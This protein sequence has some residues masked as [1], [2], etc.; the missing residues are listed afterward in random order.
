MVTVGWAMTM[1]GKYNFIQSVGRAFAILEQFSHDQRSLGVTTVANRLK[2]HK[3]TCFGL[4]HTLQ[5]LGYI[6]KDPDTG[7]YSLGLKAFE[8]GQ[9]YIGGLDLRQISR[10][11][12]LS[13]VEKTQETVHLVVLEGLRGV[14]IDKVEGS[15][16]I[17]ISSRIGQQA[18]LHCT[19]VGKVLLA[20]MP[21]EDRAQVLKLGLERYTEH[22]ITDEGQLGDHLWRIRQSGFGIDDEEIEIGL[23]CVAAPI[24]NARRQV[25]AAISIS[26]PS[27]RLTRDKFEELS[28]LVKHAAEDVSRQLGYR[29]SP[30]AAQ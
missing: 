10:P 11:H 12:L 24:F 23:R 25:I 27:S 13:L 5:E 9:A 8:L 26:G 14:Y 21:D 3:S 20:H 1:D 22:T 29:A 6:Q 16:A 7:R 18:K 17:S 2:L 4:L 30:I 28:R 15:H 19:G